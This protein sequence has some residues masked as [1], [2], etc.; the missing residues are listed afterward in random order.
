MPAGRAHTKPFELNQLF[1]SYGLARR[2]V[3]H[4]VVCRPAAKKIAATLDSRA[5]RC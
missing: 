4:G 2:L 5:T 3:K 1:F